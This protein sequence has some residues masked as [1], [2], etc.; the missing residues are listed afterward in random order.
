LCQQSFNA[1][2]YLGIRFG[3]QRLTLFA[4]LLQRGVV[5]LLHFLPVF[6]VRLSAPAIRANVIARSRVLLNEKYENQHQG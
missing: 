3:Q 6:R 5:Q 4:G 1:A 2:S